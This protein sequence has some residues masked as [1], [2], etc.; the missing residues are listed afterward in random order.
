MQEGNRPAR[1]LLFVQARINGQSV[2]EA[3]LLLMPDGRVL[4]S[5]D[6]W[7]AWRLRL[8]DGTALRHQD[9]DWWALAEA[10]GHQMQLDA[11]AQTASFEFAAAAFIT[12]QFTVNPS[13][14]TT[15]LRPEGW[16]GFFNYELVGSYNQADAA[17]NTERL[18]GQFEAVLFNRWGT[19]GSQWVALDLGD[20]TPQ[21]GFGEQGRALIRL[22]SALRMDDPTAMT[23]LVMGDAIGKSGL[24]GRATR[25]GGL[26]Y[27]RNFATQPGFVT[28]PQ[29]RLAGESALPSVL[30]VF[31]DG[32]QRQS[33]NISPGPFLIDNI[34]AVN[35]L[36]EVQVVVRDLLGR[37]QVLTL[38]YL[39][40]GQ[41]LKAG[42]HDYTMELGALRDNFG[43][44]NNDYGRFIATTQHQYG[45]SDAFTGE[46]RLE[47]REGGGLNAGGGGVLAIP[48][49]G[50]LSA[51]GVFSRD[52]AGDGALGQLS[53]QRAVRGGL[54]LGTR[55][56][57]TTRTFRQ[58]GSS[59]ELAPP[60]RL[61][62]VNAGFLIARRSN[63]GV[64]YIK[65]D[66]RDTRSTEAIT[67]NLSS[68]VFGGALSV[69][70]SQRLRPNKDLSVN[71]LFSMALAPRLTSSLSLRQ[72]QPAQGEAQT[73]MTAR[74]QRSLPDGLGYGWRAS[75][76]Q[77]R[78]GDELGGSEGTR[79][80][81]GVALNSAFGAMALEGGVDER[82]SALRATVSGSLGL[83]AESAFASRRIGNSFALVQTG[84][85][86]V[87]LRLNGQIAAISNANGMALLPNVQAYL[88]N[89]LRA[90]LDSLP[91]EVEATRS[92]AIITPY[93]RSGLNVT[94]AL[95]N[96]P[97][98]VVVLLNA[99][100]TPLPAG[101]E[102]RRVGNE[103]LLPVGRTGRVYVT[104]LVPGDNRLQQSS[105]GCMW[106]LVLLD[107][108]GLPVQPGP[109][110][111][112]RLAP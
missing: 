14:L 91:L 83:F 88:G 43:S 24:W 32:V 12:N 100:G 92:E 45:F 107:G 49:L 46:A 80:E 110:P 1:Q 71:V 42:L 102:V 6:R 47:L 5:R 78:H 29:P 27:G 33:Q 101:A 84:A 103:T 66:T 41:Q 57:T 22:D 74:A 86:D 89:Q 67:A 34:P 35:G 112:Q 50:L 70:A 63:L 20:S 98:A 53:L 28:V 87:P 97:A 16:G 52:R 90:D 95:K 2:G 56:L 38:P 77:Q 23:S 65:Q 62:G 109:Y 30:E 4:A 9:D 37:E 104:G 48:Y 72:S 94:L 69:L 99:D 76:S 93:F 96:A 21:P 39:S 111:C 106:T 17:P 61:L 55:L 19:A 15:A 85:P 79:G 40:G 82:S 73:R 60:L 75:A 36:G 105:T 81:A 44:N 68:R 26:A 58:T 13:R 64:G 25:F 59:E 54:N 108:P 7:A 11:A 8:P 51:A 10:P 3:A 18:D 31:V